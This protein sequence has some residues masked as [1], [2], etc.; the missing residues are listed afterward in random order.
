MRRSRVVGSY[1][2]VLALSSACATSSGTM[3]SSRYDVS[4]AP[5]RTT[6]TPEERDSAS[7]QTIADREGPAVSIRADVSWASNSRMTRA[8]FNLGDDAY[9]VV[10]QIDPNGV[11][12]FVFPTDPNDDGFVR[13]NRSYQTNET[14]AGFEDNF[15]YRAYQARYTTS[16]YTPYSYDRGVGYMF[17]IAS[18]RPMHLDQIGRGTNAWDT[19]EIADDSYLRDPRPAVYELASLLAG[20]N[21]EA[22]TVKF[23][24]Y[25]NTTT[26]GFGGFG[27]GNFS[28]FNSAYCPGYQS[29]GFSS[30]PFNNPVYTNSHYWGESFFY[31]GQYYGYNSSFDCYSPSNY[32]NP[33]GYGSGFGQLAQQPL[34]PPHGGLLDAP[35]HRNPLNPRAPQPPMIGRPQP[36]LPAGIQAG[37]RRLAAADEPHYNPS[38]RNRGLKTDDTPLADPAGES[39]RS[40]RVDANGFDT[41]SRPSIQ[42]MIGRHVDNQNDGRDWSHNARISND[43]TTGSMRQAW[44]QRSQNEGR[45]TNSDAQARMRTD[46]SG[47][48]SSSGQ[49][50]S[51]AQSHRSDAS[52]SSQHSYGGSS[53]PSS[54]A[55]R[56]GGA[57]TSSAPAHV[58]APA[59]SPPPAASSSSSAGPSKPK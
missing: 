29:F 39:R 44:A 52:G 6:L 11:V 32:Y 45:T 57:S 23:A 30:S 53:S 3:T 50:S 26:D 34:F 31:R 27:T 38:Y 10:G 24:T 9:V 46:V 48:S 22:Y 37:Q 13:G 8:Y 12:H 41:R 47:R 33:F 55:S 43:A 16:G 25:Y 56:A 7:A 4:P 28:A 17:V 58:A 42:Q 21:R 59:A 35:S 36:V 5:E 40:P 14:F 15:N 19:F 49:S 2:G 54:G 20:T 51:G 18:W 1:L